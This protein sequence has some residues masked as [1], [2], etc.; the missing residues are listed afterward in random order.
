MKINYL[1][2]TLDESAAKLCLLPRSFIRE[3]RV[4]EAH[5]TMMAMMTK[6]MTK[7]M[8]IIMTKMMTKIM[9][10]IMAKI[11]ARMIIILMIPYLGTLL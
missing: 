8:I 10:K 5:L 9:I 4:V 3:T 2:K 6:M 1:K 11:M 7:M